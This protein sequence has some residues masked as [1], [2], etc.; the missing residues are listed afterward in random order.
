MTTTHEWRLRQRPS[1]WPTPQDFELVETELE[2]VGPGQV[3][4]AN[5]VLSVDPYMR[6][7]MNDAHSYAEP[8]ALGAAM[9][10]GAVGRVVVSRSDRV[11]EGALV[12]SMYGWRDRFVADA[13][14]VEVLA[15]DPA[16]AV[17]DGYWLGVLGMPG[18]TA[19]VGLF[20][21]AEV[22]PGET[23]FVSAAAGAVGSLV[24][25]LAREAGC[26]VI[27]SAGG[28][29]KVDYLRSRLRVDAA[30][31]YRAGD[32]TGQLRSAAPQGVDV[33]FDNVGGEHLQA[34]LSAMNP[35]GRIA[36]CG[37]ISAYN[38]SAEEP[39]VGPTNLA[40]VVGRKLT[41][42]GFIV[43]DHADRGPAFARHVGGLLRSG[44]LSYDLTEVAG[45]DQMA[46]AFLDLLAGGRHTGKLVVTLPGPGG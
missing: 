27:G 2:A 5:T 17:P 10:G 14:Q 12:R 31:D 7:R 1:G 39:P 4:V 46:Q 9:T 29:A 22:R 32:L 42:R 23:V 8:Y 6:G 34:A 15:A 21:I 30:L 45:L 35:H 41:L 38:A 26:R 44:R 13:R 33:Y 19:W 16:A 40:L 18:L 36:A 37:M 3:E 28:G 25:Q 11:A 20:D 24:C 43:S